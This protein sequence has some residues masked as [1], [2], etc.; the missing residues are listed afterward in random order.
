MQSPRL[1]RAWGDRRPLWTH[2]WYVREGQWWE[3]KGVWW[4]IR[5]LPRSVKRFVV[6]QAAVQAQVAN[7]ELY[8]DLVRYVDMAKV[9]A[10]QPK[11]N[12]VQNAL[13][14][15]SWLLRAIR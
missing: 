6:V 5:L 8:P 11:A 3:A 4:V 15:A 1:N 9:Y 2:W 10:K 12:N 7:R 13:W 14:L